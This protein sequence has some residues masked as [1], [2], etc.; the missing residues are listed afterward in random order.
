L[1]RRDRALQA[2]NYS[3][4][5]T[6]RDGRRAQIRALRPDDRAELIAAVSRVSDRSL[7]RRFFS[8]KHHFTEPEIEFFTN[9]DF[10]SHVVLVAIVDESGRPTIVGGARYV[11]VQPGKAEVAFTVVDQ[12]QGQG[13]GAALMHHLA[14][15]AIGAGLRELIAEVLPDNAPMLKVFQKSGYPLSIKRE[16]QVMH[17]SLELSGPGMLSSRRD[18][19]GTVPIEP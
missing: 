17:V 2:V 13:L 6:L 12:Y 3:A 1:E 7:Y 8:V 10:V 4:F 11:V 9:V 5:E 16:P 15:L 18:G 19:V 14:N